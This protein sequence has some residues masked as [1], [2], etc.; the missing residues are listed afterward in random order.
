MATGGLAVRKIST[1]HC[2]EFQLWKNDSYSFETRV[3]ADYKWGGNGLEVEDMDIRKLGL[4]QPLKEGGIINWLR[5][6]QAEPRRQVCNSSGGNQRQCGIS[7]L[8]M[9]G[10]V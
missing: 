8:S 6:E 4:T 5:S 9:T 2:E 1:G 10:R 3:N 7:G